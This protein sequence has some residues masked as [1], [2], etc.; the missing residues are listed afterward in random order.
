MADAKVI[1]IRSANNAAQPSTGLH[2]HVSERSIT[3]AHAARS[4]MEHGGDARYLPRI[5]A[6]IGDRPLSSIHPF[7]VRQLAEQLYPDCKP[8]TRNR[9]AIT[10]CRAVL[11]HGYDRGWCN[12]VRIRNF[13][14]A[15]SARKPPANAL[16][17]QCFMRQC[18]QDGLHHLAAAVLM[19]ATT[20]A[21]VSEA[22]ALEWSEVDL[23]LRRATLLK[24]KTTTHSVRYLTDDLC[25]RLAA[26][27]DQRRHGR[28][29][30]YTS[31]QAVNERIKAVC[32]RAGISYKSS[33]L[34]GRHTYATRAIAMGIDVRT[35][36]AGGDW[37]SST[38]F[39]ET[40]VRPSEHAGR[41]VADRLNHQDMAMTL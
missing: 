5:I 31:R 33:H 10:P 22:I 9:Q 3:F 2:H 28:V 37:K 38:I 17:L 18:D 36:M 27:K 32:R 29:F 4:Y 21:R 23:G 14:E 6:L 34:C 13:R 16:W 7:D 24:T 19:M 15:K 35:A 1:A 40:Y 41:I 30:R 12:A 25:E 26:L 8:S 20:A 11:Y 39:L